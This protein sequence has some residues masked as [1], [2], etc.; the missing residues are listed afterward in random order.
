M[1][2]TTTII[3]ADCKVTKC[4]QANSYRIQAY[5]GAPTLELASINNTQTFYVN[6][7]GKEGTPNFMDVWYR[8]IGGKRIICV[9][10]NKE[11]KEKTWIARMYQEIEG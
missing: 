9:A 1:E 5:W 7:I 8:E 11:R 10:F 3:K 6:K 2:T 4:I